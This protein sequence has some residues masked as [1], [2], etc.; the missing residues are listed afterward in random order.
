MGLFDQ[1]GRQANLKLQDQM[2]LRFDVGYWTKRKL[3]VLDAFDR[4]LCY[5]NKL[6]DALR[7]KGRFAEL[8]ALNKQMTVKGGPKPKLPTVEGV[9]TLEEYEKT[10]KN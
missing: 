3:V 8:E 10:L 4:P 9:E 2:I 1:Q 5:I 6:K 7:A